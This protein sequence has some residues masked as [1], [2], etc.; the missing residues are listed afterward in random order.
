VLVRRPAGSTLD[1]VLR[2]SRSADEM[3]GAVFAL[4]GEESVAGVWM[5]AE[6]AV[7]GDP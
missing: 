7:G 4:A 6:Q 2:R 1:A 5:A 3:L